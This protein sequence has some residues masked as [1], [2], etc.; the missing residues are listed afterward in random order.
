MSTIKAKKNENETRL[1]ISTNALFVSVFARF[2]YVGGVDADFFIVFLEC[3]KVFTCLRKLT[4][5]ITEFGV[6]ILSGRS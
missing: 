6:N 1:D 5:V 3:G 2:F 4:L